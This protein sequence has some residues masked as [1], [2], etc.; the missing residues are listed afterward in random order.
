MGAKVP[1]FLLPGSCV[2]VS[3]GTVGNDWERI[4]LHFSIEIDGNQNDEQ[5]EGFLDLVQKAGAAH[6]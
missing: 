4:E 2:P 3:M 6:P 5:I 1:P